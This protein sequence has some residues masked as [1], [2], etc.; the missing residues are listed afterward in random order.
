MNAALADKMVGALLHQGCVVEPNSLSSAVARLERLAFGRV[1]PEACNIS[2]N[3]HELSVMQTECLVQTRGMGCAGGGEK[4]AEKFPNK[5][6]VSLRF[7]QLVISEVGVLAGPGWNWNGPE[8]R[9]RVVPELRVGDKLLQTGLEPMERR[10]DAPPLEMDSCGPTSF[11]VPF[12]FSSERPIEPVYDGERAAGVVARRPA[13]TEG[14]IEVKAQPL[15]GR[16]FK[17]SAR[18]TNL[19]PFTEESMRDPDALLTCTF[20][21]THMLLKVR[22]GEFISLSRPAAAYGRAAEECTNIGTW[23]VLVGDEARCECDA[24]LSSP[25]M[26]GDYPKLASESV[27][28]LASGR[29]SAEILCL[30][31]Q[32]MAE[33]EKVEMRDVA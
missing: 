13:M 15:G 18:L 10:I 14:K 1:Y 31:T 3:G 8:P 12:R 9:F 26:F 29:Q 20:V 22:N 23:P 17:V 19:T 4:E 32:T 6:C 24:M 25:F 5:F 11:T 7:L 21:A 16:L 2:H 27:G 28:A 33:L 30:H